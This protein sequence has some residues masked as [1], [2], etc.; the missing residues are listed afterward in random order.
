M[1]LKQDII[2]AEVE[3]NDAQDYLDSKE[4]EMTEG[5]VDSHNAWLKYQRAHIQSLH[6]QINTILAGAKVAVFDYEF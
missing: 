4:C 6:K 5:E 1:N 2:D 3:L